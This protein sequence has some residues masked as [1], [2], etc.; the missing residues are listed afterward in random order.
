MS[1]VYELSPRERRHD[2]AS[3][4]IARLDRKLDPEEEAA[5]QQWMAA[6]PENEATL[7]EMA[8]LWDKMDS[9]TRLSSLFSP[10]EEKRRRFPAPVAAG[11]AALVLAA[12]S[13]WLIWHGSLEQ[14][15]PVVAKYVYQTDIGE[16][17]NVVL[18]DGT[19]L[20]L[21]T[22]SRITAKYTD[23]HR[24]LTLERGEVYVTVARDRDRPLSVLAGDR[25]V[26]AVGTEFNL[27]I[28]DKQ[29]I[30]LVVLEGKVKIGVR[31]ADDGPMDPDAP[32]LA[33]S[34]RTLVANQTTTLKSDREEIIEVSPEDIAVNLSWRNGNLIFRGES[35]EEAVREI[36][37]YTPVEFVFLNEE[38]KKVRVAGLFKA[39]DVEGLLATLRENFNIVYQKTDDKKVLLGNR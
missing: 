34:S 36:E 23:G 6:D 25:I 29:Q 2:E 9:L 15:Q 1:N 38:L 18:P 3:Q 37:R 4:W 12:V 39:G 35:L 28:T 17:S 11:I 22:H 26:Q 10:P 8:R 5:L 27:Q 7:L 13:L 30:E 31:D 19:R 24:L 16:R 33:P 14:P 32:V 21:N 20:E